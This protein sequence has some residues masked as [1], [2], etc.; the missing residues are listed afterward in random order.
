MEL[1]DDLTNEVIE[2]CQ[3]GKLLA[4]APQSDELFYTHE[5]G[6]IDFDIRNVSDWFECTDIRNEDTNFV[7]L[8]NLTKAIF[9]A[10]LAFYQFGPDRIDRA[11]MDISDRVHAPVIASEIVTAL[12]RR[13]F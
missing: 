13:L 12:G 4:G 3:S 6:R 8:M 5:D 9:S 11:V 2:W 10:Q 7:E 1:F